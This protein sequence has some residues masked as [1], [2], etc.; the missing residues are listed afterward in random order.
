MGAGGLECFGTVHGPVASEK[1]RYVMDMSER[2]PW[3]FLRED[4]WGMKEEIDFVLAIPKECPRCARGLRCP[5][6]DYAREIREA[7]DAEI[8]RRKQHSRRSSKSLKQ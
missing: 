6:C 2:K 7:V 1:G 8:E 5:M 3:H 4:D